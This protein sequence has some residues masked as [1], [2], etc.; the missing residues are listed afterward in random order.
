MYIQ[1]IISNKFDLNWS[2]S[3]SYSRDKH[4]RLQ[5]C[6]VIKIVK[7]FI[8]TAFNRSS[9]TRTF[10]TSLSNAQFYKTFSAQFKLWHDKLEC[11]FKANIFFLV[12]CLVKAI[13]IVMSELVKF[14]SL[15]NLLELWSD[16]FPDRL[17]WLRVSQRIP[18]F[19]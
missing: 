8:A 14:L 6:S 18:L 15:S 17:H 10:T 9:L 7:S 5:H 1:N 3:F 2:S 19:G 13:Y 12:Y 16:H 11:L 4:P